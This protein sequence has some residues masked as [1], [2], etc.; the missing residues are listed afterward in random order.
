MTK[1]QALKRWLFVPLLA[2]IFL[3]VPWGVAKGA[4]D[5]T[6]HDI[7]VSVDLHPD[8]SATLSEV[9]DMTTKEGTEIYKPLKL[10]SGQRLED[11]T[12]TM[13][14]QPLQYND[15]WDVD[16]SFEEKAGTYGYNDEEELNWGIT[17]YGRHQYRATYTITHFVMQTTTDQMIFWQFINEGLAVPPDHIKI[18]LKSDVGPMT[19]EGQY[20]VWGF[21]FQGETSFNDGMIIAEST[22]AL[23]GKGKGV[24]LIHIPSG[25]FSGAKQMNR[26]FDDYAKSAFEGSRYNWKD[27]KN[28]N[29]LLKGGE[30]PK[31][32]IEKIGTVIIAGIGGLFALLGVSAFIFGI[33]R[34]YKRKKGKNKYYP[35]LKARSQQLQG[36][37]YRDLPTENVFDGYLL[38]WDLSLKDLG[39]KYFVVALLI[40]VRDKAMQLTTDEK[41]K[42]AIR[43]LNE[44]YEPDDDVL[45]F[46]WSLLKEAMRVEGSEGLLSEKGLKHYLK[47]HTNDLLKYVTKIEMQSKAA[48]DRNQWENS[49]AAHK[50]PTLKDYVDQVVKLPLSEKGFTVRDN[51]VRFYNYLKDFSLLN[52]REVQEV[53]L[54]DQL[55]IYAAALGI[56]DEVAETFAHLNPQFVEQ[57][58]IITPHFS[59]MDYYIWSNLIDNFYVESAL[60]SASSSA[61]F[62]GR[63]S[64]G[65]G[66]GSFGGG[67]GGGAR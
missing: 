17:S 22:H 3:V 18:T 48:A 20:N 27:Y 28:R 53:A 63:T 29:T 47:G 60:T 26:S 59:M 30:M 49:L 56:A 57:S 31:T 25:T 58:A 55:L 38:L 51:Y 19:P 34:E 6:I 4:V 15:D 64:I 65:G 50:K 37:Y 62:G 67:F 52:E 42:M 13:D 35:S 16:A 24:L 32:L 23:S 10:V 8:G 41:G 5:Q 43:M 12:V 39:N 1:R 9:W 61:G 44:D 7:D 54:W 46:L 2:F 66:G 36:E 45:S 14:G 11:Y 21:G 40:L 33:R